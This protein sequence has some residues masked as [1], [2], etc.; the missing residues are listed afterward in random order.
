MGLK[1]QEILSSLGVQLDPVSE[2]GSLLHPSIH[3]LGGKMDSY[4][5]GTVFENHRKSLIQHCERSK[6]C[7]HFG[8]KVHWKG[9]KWSILASFWKPEACGQTVLP[10]RSLLKG[11][12]LVEMP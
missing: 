7:L 5:Y 2:L 11:Q 12:K 8:W 3:T 6:L 4:S 1:C 10:D 9:Q